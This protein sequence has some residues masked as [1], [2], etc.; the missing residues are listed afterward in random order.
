MRKKE[1]FTG[2]RNEKEGRLARR[3][4]QKEG[5]L[6]WKEES[7]RRKTFLEGGV[8]KKEEYPGRIRIDDNV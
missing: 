2:K 4:N 5:R 1:D 6:S 8:S 3:R 7:E